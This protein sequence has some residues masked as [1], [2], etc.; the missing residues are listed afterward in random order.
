[1]AILI[2][3]TMPGSLEALPDPSGTR[4][5]Q[6]A[7]SRATGLGW[8]RRSVR[9]QLLAAVIL[10]DLVAAFVAFG[11]TVFKA[12][13]STRVEIAASMRL[14]ELLINQTVNLLREQDAP[15]K[16][17][18]DL[19]AR[20]SFLRHVRVTV[21]DAAGEPVA[22]APIQKSARNQRSDAP[23]W[24]AALVGWP[25]DRREIPVT[26]SGRH[27]GSVWV[28]EEPR[29]E[30]AEA[31]ENTVALG[32]VAAG[33]NIAVILALYFWFGRVLHPLAGV[34]GG[35]FDLEQ[36]N[37]RVRLTRPRA[38]ELAIITDRFNALAEA[39][40]AARR[41]N[42]RLARRLIT[43]QDDERRHIARELHDEVGPCLFGLKANA[44]S[45]ATAVAA[46]TPVAERNVKQRVTDILAI[47]GR[48]QAMNRSLLNRMRPMAL[49]HVPLHDLLAELV[50]DCARQHP[51]LSFSF[52][53]DKLASSYGDSVDLTIYRCIQ[54]SLTN[55]VRHA[56]AHCVS[57]DVGESGS[58]RDRTTDHASPRLRVSVRDDG[59]GMAPQTPMGFGLHGMRE[60]V[61]ALGGEC[62][63]ESPSGG[64]TCVRIEMPVPMRQDEPAKACDSLKDKYPV[65]T[66]DTGE[67]TNVL[68]ADRR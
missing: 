29:D 26:I 41:E 21:T 23:A 30:I 18:A 37:Y 6:T 31:W 25:V 14:A 8:H 39:L 56:Q 22:A 63:L 48:L 68:R 2:D 50:R 54:E 60:R 24:F 66:N 55:A 49:G 45:I 17:L 62:T 20:L 51:N 43:A 12:R 9:F 4:L 59:R 3:Q 7:G 44:T 64:G 67:E 47:V 27:V 33:L 42:I 10:I 36:R 57:I 52:S 58:D 16:F 35:L 28:L 46:S 11:V 34:A 13:T 61:Q 65:K 15:D 32:L 1:M 53:A 40:D 38:R 19:P 5:P